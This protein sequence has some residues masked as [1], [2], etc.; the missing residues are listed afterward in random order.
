MEESFFVICDGRL[1]SEQSATSSDFQLLIGFAAARR[2]EFHSFR[3][4]HSAS[5]SRIVPA[6]LNRLNSVQYS[7]AEIAWV[8]SLANQLLP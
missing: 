2:R 5:V 7:P 6:S 4:S 1:N 3:I 8:E